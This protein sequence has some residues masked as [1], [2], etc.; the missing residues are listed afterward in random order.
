VTLITSI[1]SMIVSVPLRRPVRLSRQTFTA[2]EFNVVRVETDMGVTGA[3]YARGGRLVHAAIEHELS[4]L[5]VG[6]DAAA[7]ERHW[8]TAYEQTAL[9]GRGGAVLR[10]LSALDI[11]LWDIRAKVAGMP[12]A[13]LLGATDLTVPAYVS[14]G[15]YRDGQ[16]F[17]EVAAEMA[18]YVDDGFRA[19]K[20]RIGGLPWREDVARVAAVRAAIGDDVELAVDANQAYRSSAEAIRVG[21]QLEELGVRWLEEPLRPEDAPA[22]AQVARVL[23][24]PIATGETEAGRWAFRDLVACGAADVLQPDVTVVGGV[25]EWM[26]VAALAGANGLPVAPHYFPEVHAHLVAAASAATTIEWFSPDADI[27]SFDAF[28]EEP[29]RP[30]AG[31]VTVSETPGVGLNLRDDALQR[32]RI[33]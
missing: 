4:S 19:V 14:G 32:H 1:T 10:G 12:L 17:D 28:L 30:R 13:R 16:T 5:L 24:L 21:R 31:K 9:V 27:I 20:I 22:M 15:Y 23:D 3:G 7:I 33:A 6:A 8:E 25:S 2:R 11:A 18:S 26:N 29:L